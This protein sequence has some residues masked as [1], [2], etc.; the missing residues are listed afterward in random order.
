MGDKTNVG[1]SNAKYSL[2]KGSIGDQDLN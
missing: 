2:K 1:Y